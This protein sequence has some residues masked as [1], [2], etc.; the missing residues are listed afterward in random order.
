MERA[1]PLVAKGLEGVNSRKVLLSVL[2]ERL[3]PFTLIVK[4]QSLL[5][6]LRD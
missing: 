2:Y 6:L 5:E 4:F 1:N 3:L